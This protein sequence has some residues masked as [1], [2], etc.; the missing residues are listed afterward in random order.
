MK[1]I[2]SSFELLVFVV[3]FKFVIKMFFYFMTTPT[4]KC[5]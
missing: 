5:C 3:Y 1:Q 4:I 2:H